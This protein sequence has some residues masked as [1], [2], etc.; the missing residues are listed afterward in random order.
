MADNR[1]YL[2]H[3]EEQGNI[4]IAEDVVVAIATQALVETEGV[5]AMMSQSMVDQLTELV[6]KKPSRGVHMEVEEGG[7][8]LD[9]CL[10][11]EYGFAIPELA[12]KVQE[13]VSSAVTSM[14]GFAVKAV[15]VHVGGVS[16]N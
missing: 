6:G 1:E 16:F 5:S 14:T 13:N 12:A 2:T 11:V 10:L 3:G 4:N 15:N 8:V 9:V 7:I